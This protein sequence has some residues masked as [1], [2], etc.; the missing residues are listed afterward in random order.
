MNIADKWAIEDRIR[1]NLANWMATHGKVLSDRQQS[2]AYCGIRFL[3]IAW[4]GN[5][6]EITEVDG[7]AVELKKA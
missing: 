1:G 2:N 3:E 5:T 7:L 6:Y 4:R